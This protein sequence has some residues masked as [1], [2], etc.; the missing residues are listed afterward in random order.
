MRSSTSS[1]LKRFISG[2]TPFF[3]LKKRGRVVGGSEWAGSGLILDLELM[4][5]AEEEGEGGECE[6][7]IWEWLGG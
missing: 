1:L 4:E 6:K 3:M 5:E 2:G 7:V